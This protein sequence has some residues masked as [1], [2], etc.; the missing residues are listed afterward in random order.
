[1]YII[2]S[3]KY[4]DLHFA[5]LRMETY[6]QPQPLALSCR[7]FGSETVGGCQNF[8][9]NCNRVCILIIYFNIYEQYF[10][11]KNAMR[12][13][14]RPAGANA[15]IILGGQQ[16]NHYIFHGRGLC[17]PIIWETYFPQKSLIQLEKLW[18][19]RDYTCWWEKYA[20]LP[21]SPNFIGLCIVL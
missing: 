15:L 21:V 5:L 20:T 18:C 2:P 8:Y 10:W 11:V 3:R 12:R 17:V 9:R 16:A 7:I 19:P 4:H 13:K 14:E 1:M 6:I